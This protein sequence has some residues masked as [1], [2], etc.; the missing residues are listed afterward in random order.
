[1]LS[2]NH[3]VVACLLVFLAAGGVAHRFAAQTVSPRSLSAVKSQAD[4]DSLAVTYDANTPY[5]LPHVLFVIDRK[6]G[7]RIY[8]VDTKRFAFHKDFVNGTYLSL[9]R[10]REFFENNYLKPNRRFILGTIAYQTP[11]KR[12]TF[13]FWEGDLIPAD[14]I[15]IAADVINRSFF[16]PVAYKPNSNRQDEATRTLAGVQRVLQSDIAKEQEYQALNLAKGIGRIHVIP[17]L[18]EHVEIGFNE[19][20]VLD[21]APIQLPPVAGIITSKPSTPLSHIN[22]LAKG[23]GIP[24]AYIKNAQTLLKQYDGWWVTFETR[25]DNYSIKRADVDQLREYQKRLA[26]RLDVVKPKFDLSETRLLGL[27]QQR[28]HSSIAFGGKSANLGELMNARLPGIQVPNGFTVPFYYYDQFLK[29]NKLDDAIY[30]LLN[31]QKFV[32][33]P[34]YRREHLTELRRRIEQGTFDEK[35]RAQIVRRARLEFPNK[36]LFVRSSSNSEDLPNFSG[37]GLYSTVPNVKGDQQLIDAVKTVWASL[38]NFEAYEARERMAVD[39][40][41]IFMAVLIQEGINSESSGVMITTDPYN[42]ENKGAIYISA[43]RGLGIKVVEG[44]K[45]AEQII[46]LPRANAIQVLT[47][48]DEDSL[49]T[50][51]E[52]GGVKEIAITGERIVL[53]DAVVRRLVNA[54]TAIKRV[55]GSRDQDIEW[56]YMKGQ[57]YIVQSRPFIAGG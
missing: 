32:H 3:F 2:R 28:A 30:A 49:L 51:D 37:A 20:L 54:A 55:F 23:W 50:F 8:Y 41:K 47:R 48:S 45:V 46:F 25:R 9:E 6:D 13:E 57:I 39:H 14:Q 35:L 5:A 4:F 29:A 15:K 21:E 11:I 44:K 22:L 12:W 33:D 43:K 10:G 27:G 26:Q 38:W 36:G 40:S 34:A 19:I 17:K 53:T 31:D 42:K 18:D 1:M 56:A 24:N 16:V 52:K 7:N